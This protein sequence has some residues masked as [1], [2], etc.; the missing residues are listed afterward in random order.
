MQTIFLIKE[1]Q[2][3]RLTSMTLPWF[4]SFL[5]GTLHGMRFVPAPAAE[6]TS[7]MLEL[8]KTK[9]PQLRA[10]VRGGHRP[11]CCTLS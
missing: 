3:Y 5:A 7:A 11:T 6:V 2:S 4:Y 10:V 8:S 9:R 1:V